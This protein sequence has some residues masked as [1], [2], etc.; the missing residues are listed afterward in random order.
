MMLLCFSRARDLRQAHHKPRN[1]K[2][3]GYCDPTAKDIFTMQTVG[4]AAQVGS[5]KMHL[6]VV[7][8]AA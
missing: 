8:G 4:H 7:G 2:A 3:A 6:D 1:K 5:E